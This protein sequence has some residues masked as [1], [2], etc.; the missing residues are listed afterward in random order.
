MTHASL[1]LLD[2][3]Q[4][5][6]VLRASHG[7]KR[8]S[9]QSRYAIPA[10]HPLIRWQR[11][12]RRPFT[13]EESSQFHP[14]LGR[15]LAA[16]ES[17]LVIPGLMEHRLLGFLAL[18][19]KRSGQPYSA[20]DLHAFSTLANEAAVALENATSYEALLKANEQLQ[21]ASQR[22][23]RQE[24]LVAAGQ[25]AAGMA[26]EIKNPL[27]AIKTF[28]QFLPEKYADPAFR[29][30]FFRIVQ[31]E[32]DRINDIVKELS[33][34]AR[35]SPPQL[36]PVRL[37]GLVEDTM[38]LLSNQCLNQGV[39]LRHSGNEDGLSID[40]DPQQMKQVL[41]NLCLNSLEAMT[42][43]GRLELATVAEAGY[44]VLRV[45]DTGPGVSPDCL[46]HVWDPFFTTKE[47][48]MGLGLA[49]VKGIVER[50]G[51][52]IRLTS[53]PRRGTLVEVYLPAHT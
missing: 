13:Q 7:P 47:R 28:A 50:H 22:L 44:L 15:E 27:S 9:L 5:T 51:G 52:T 16:L 12:R 45:K 48:G 23:L 41:L 14:A 30:K 18:G 19:P 31:E 49:I 4:D 21:A 6:Y 29:D 36:R 37:S 35:P 8:R 53:E 25:F 2:P 17:V 10:G 42:G 40:A 1:F 26:H 24:R 39:E 46:A 3:E 32:I 20:D 11:D 34:F 38:A 43:G 33:D